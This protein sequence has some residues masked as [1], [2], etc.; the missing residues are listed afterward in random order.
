NS[1]PYGFMIAL[2]VFALIYTSMLIV[3]MKKGQTLAVF[4]LGFALD[5]V[6]LLAGW[7]AV[8]KGY[9]GSS[10]TNDLYLI[11][12]PNLVFAVSRLGVILGSGYV[13][14]WMAWMA[15]SWLY[16]YDHSGYDVKQLPVRVLFIMIT[17]GL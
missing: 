14:L 6:T 3:P 7:L 9:A 17:S 15:G 12:M 1:Q 4:F 5:N 2:L 10:I 8:V 16:Y 11:L 13:V